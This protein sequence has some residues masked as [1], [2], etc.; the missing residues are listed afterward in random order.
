MPSPLVARKAHAGVEPVRKSSRALR[1]NRSPNVQFDRL[2]AIVLPGQACN[3]ACTYCY[4]YDRSGTARMPAEVL[5]ETMRQLIESIRPGGTLKV[6]WHGGEPSLVG[7]SFLQ[8]AVAFQREFNHRELDHGIHIRNSIQTNGIGLD[9]DLLDLLR[10][11]RF[12]VGVS[13]DG[14]PEL[15]DLCRTTKRGQGTFDRV[16]AGVRKLREKKVRFGAIC[17]ITKQNKDHIEKIYRF[18]HDEE[19]PF[20]V[21]PLICSGAAKE[22][23]DYHRISPVEYADVVLE[24][25]RLWLE[26]RDAGLPVT[27]IDEIVTSLV[28]G[29]NTG[30]HGSPNCQENFVAV[31]S[32]GDVYPCGRFV[33]RKPFRFGNLMTT[34]FDQVLMGPP[35]GLL[36]GRDARAMSDCRNC[37]WRPICHGGCMHN[38]A[39]GEGTAADKDPLCSAYRRVFSRVA[40][41][42]S[43]FMRDRG[44]EPEPA[45]TRWLA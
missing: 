14:P 2:T 35:R 31:D 10:R 26:D 21:N 42:L 4:V 25:F 15:H 39:E 5:R 45:I 11:S 28:T 32:S 27:T 33:S 24:L 38:A 34:P 19:I 18:F 41:E 43:A 44:L 17:V 37:R 7:A 16:M 1:E 13:I 36:L 30:C 8:S 6:I 20:R 22:N 12:S 23:L 29:R 9:D 3:I 40:V